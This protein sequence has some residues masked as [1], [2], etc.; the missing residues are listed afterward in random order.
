MWFGFCAVEAIADTRVSR[1]DLLG[2]FYEG[3][4]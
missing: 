3:F 4:G 2:R 1:L